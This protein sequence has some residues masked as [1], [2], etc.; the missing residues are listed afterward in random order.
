MTTQRGGWNAELTGVM[1]YSLEGSLA[2]LERRPGLITLTLSRVTAE[3]IQPTSVIRI[4]VAR[5]RLAVGD[6]I[7]YGSVEIR[8]DDGSKRRF[9]GRDSRTK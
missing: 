3:G 7:G 9:V 5:D 2:V 1:S 4:E 8:G 6:V